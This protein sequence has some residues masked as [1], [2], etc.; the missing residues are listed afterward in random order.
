[1]CNGQLRKKEVIPKPEQH[2]MSVYMYTV[3]DEK[4]FRDICE[5][6]KALDGTLLKGG[7]EE[8]Q[9]KYGP[10]HTVVCSLKSLQ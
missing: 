7:Q 5:E 4:C 10:K 2:S 6:L 9:S 1:M 3:H 8:G